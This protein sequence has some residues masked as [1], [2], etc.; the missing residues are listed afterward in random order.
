MATTIKQTE[1]VPEAYPDVPDDS[2]TAAAA[3]D[4]DMMWQRIEAYIAHRWTE[5]DVTWVVEGPGDW[6]PP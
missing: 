1:A 4:A 3:L 5:R 6:H 2:S